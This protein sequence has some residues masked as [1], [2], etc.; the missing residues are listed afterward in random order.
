[1]RSEVLT[2][3]KTS[4]SVLRVVTPY[5]LV[6]ADTSVLEKNAAIFRAQTLICTQR[7]TRCHYPE[8]Q[9]DNLFAV[10]LLQLR[11]AAIQKAIKIRLRL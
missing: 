4:S 6:T 2:A 1:M 5:G 9:H 7:S 3:M 10:F 8:H 11:A